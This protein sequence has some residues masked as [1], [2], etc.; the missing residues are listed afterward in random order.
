M[1]KKLLLS[2]LLVV[3]ILSPIFSKAQD[4]KTPLA[5]LPFVLSNGALIANPADVVTI[6]EIVT[7]EF[8][9]KTRFT[10]LDRS[11]FESIIKELKIQSMEQFLNSKIVDQGKQM[12]AKYLV[13]GVVTEYKVT[14][15]TK[16]WLGK[17]IT[18]YPCAL[19]MSF[20]V[21]VVET[22]QL[23]FNSPINVITNDLNSLDSLNSAQRALV[24]LQD[25]VN[26]Q[27]KNILSGSLQV[28][29]IDKTGKDGL[30]ATVL[31]NGGGTVITGKE[32]VKLGVYVSEMIGTYHR[33]KQIAELKT[34]TVQ[35]EV[36]LCDVKNGGKDLDVAIKSKTPM[37]VKILQ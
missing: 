35:G 28:L 13:A 14:K 12:G 15:N 9:Q 26:K 20:G 34:S 36:V 11:K 6:Q 8:S 31:I 16:N 21:I 19:K 4:E 3:L 22:G 10:V 7:K 1:R 29:G 32:K 30:P 23:L 25:E 17:K 33:E 18:S 24:E 27:I 5:I 37:T 2:W